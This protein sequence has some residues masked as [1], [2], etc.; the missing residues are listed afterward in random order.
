LSNT[1]PIFFVDSLLSCH[2]CLVIAALSLSCHCLIFVRLFFIL[3][4]LLLFK[5]GNAHH[6][7]D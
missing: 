7:K 6:P 1:C 3:V 5:L 2:C 4:L